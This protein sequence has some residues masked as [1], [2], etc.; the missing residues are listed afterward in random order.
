M[1]GVLAGDGAVRL[2]SRR[3]VLRRRCNNG[4]DRLKTHGLVFSEAEIKPPL[5]FAMDAI[6]TPA[7]ASADCNVLFEDK[8]IMA[9]TLW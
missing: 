1:N 4:S 5:P 7:A 9:S 2:R 3:S 6:S 8:S